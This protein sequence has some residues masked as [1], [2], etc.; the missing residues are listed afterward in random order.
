MSPYA[1]SHSNIEQSTLLIDIA[2]RNVVHLAPGDSV[3]E[4]ARIM[5]EN[6]ISSIV[7]TDESGHPAGIITERNMLHAM[8]TGCPPQTALHELMSSPVITVHESTTCLNAYQVCLRDGI[9]HLVIVDDE[10]LL[11]GVVSETDFRLHMNLSTLSGRRQIVSVMSR[12]VFSLSPNACLRDALSLM[13]AHRDTCVVV[14]EAGIPI[15]IVTERDVNFR[16]VALGRNPETTLLSDIMT[17]SPDT[18]SFDAP[19]SEALEM[20]QTYGYR[21][22]PVEKNGAV[23]GVVSM[24]DLFMEVKQELEDDIH[25]RE[26]FMFGSGYSIPVVAH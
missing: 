2:T 26:E 6:R 24:R 18:L 17:K 4:A 11:L 14:L 25:E 15:G 9:R 23:V 1:V 7:V 13:D 8:Q 20:I 16:V 19:V 12:S 21:H 22:V 3:G 5:A 10:K